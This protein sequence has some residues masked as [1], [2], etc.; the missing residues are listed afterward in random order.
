MNH[1]EDEVLAELRAN[2]D[3]AAWIDALDAAGDPPGGVVLPPVSEIPGVLRDLGV[4]EEDIAEL[5]QA[6]PNETETP[7]IWRLLELTT[8]AIVGPMGTVGD[9]PALPRWSAATGAAGRG[10][11]VW[12]YLAGLPFIRAFHRERGIPDDVSR[13]TIADLGRNVRHGRSLTGHAAVADP[14]WL[15]LHLRGSLYELGRLQFERA[16]VGTR[17]SAALAAAGVAAEPGDSALSVHIP[18][19]A[20]PLDP[21]ACAESFARAAAFFARHFPEERYEI[22][23]CYS[24][25]LDDALAEYLPRTSNIIRFTDRFQP[26]YRFDANDDTILRFVFGRGDLPLDA[27]PQRTTLER[28]VITHLE[29]GRHWHG[30][31]GWLR[32]PGV[33]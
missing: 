13:A 26:A 9:W 7:A 18:A 16:T 5:I 1:D 20:G 28:G 3:T 22:A 30:G 25:M 33:G 31:A 23:F 24:W 27:Y 14:W 11:Y 2:D 19:F 32:L 15:A 4:T 8:W 12:V 10:F 29:S 21:A 6:V 17:L